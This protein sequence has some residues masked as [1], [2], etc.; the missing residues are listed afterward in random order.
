MKHILYI[1]ALIA[2]LAGCLSQHVETRE[3]VPYNVSVRKVLGIEVSR[4]EEKV[5]TGK[6]RAAEDARVAKA[7]ARAMYRWIAAACAVG[8]ILA[9][10][11]AYVS[12]LREAAGAGII[13]GLA[14]VA[15][16]WMSV[17]ALKPWVIICGIA[18]CLIAAAIHFK[19]I[20]FDLIAKI[21]DRAK[22]KG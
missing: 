20:D 2:I 19:L 6:E 3:G 21:K 4:S 5:L 13:L 12:R 1:S 14:S 17:A 9:F 10:L 8:A 11:A 22:Q 16:M 15:L 18:A 7:K